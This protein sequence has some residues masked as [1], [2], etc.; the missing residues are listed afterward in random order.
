MYRPILAIGAISLMIVGAALSTTTTTSASEAE[1]ETKG[2][3]VVATTLSPTREE[4]LQDEP[5]LEPEEGDEQEVP[6]TYVPPIPPPPPEPPKIQSPF[7]GD[8]STVF[9]DGANY[10]CGWDYQALGGW[11]WG[12]PS[13]PCNQQFIDYIAYHCSANDGIVYFERC[14]QWLSG[15]LP[16][17]Q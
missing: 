7:I 3:L 13:D 9:A 1:A 6:M 15:T 5:F 4:S 16:I 8:A 2:Q 10:I 14:D 17:Q 12:L 11:G